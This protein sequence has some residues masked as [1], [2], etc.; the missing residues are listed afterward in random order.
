MVSQHENNNKPQRGNVTV[1]RQV[2]HIM[3]IHISI[4]MITIDLAEN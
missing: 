4:I 1:W 3:N 2:L